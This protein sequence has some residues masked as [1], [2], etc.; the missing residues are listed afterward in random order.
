MTDPAAGPVTTRRMAKLYG[1][2]LRRLERTASDRHGR[3]IE[4]R[5]PATA[6]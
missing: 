1:E 6:G 4:L 3:F 5:L 2:V